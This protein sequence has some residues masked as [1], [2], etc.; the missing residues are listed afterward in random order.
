M[1]YIK[2]ILAI[3]LLVAGFSTL[4]Y[5]RDIADYLFSKKSRTVLLINPIKR[6]ASSFN[7]LSE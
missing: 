7:S 5:L 4:M 2:F 1:Q 6:L 3:G